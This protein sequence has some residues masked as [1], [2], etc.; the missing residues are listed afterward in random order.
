MFLDFE[1]IENAR[2]LGG[3]IR[4]DGA[5]IREGVLLRTGHLQY[6]SERD[7]ARLADMGVSL[8]VDFRDADEI[9]RH[10]DK[11]LPGAKRMHLPAL[12]DLRTLFPAVETA[13]PAQARV[14]FREMYKY[15]AI[16]P[17][18]ITAYGTLFR[19]LLAAKGKP[20][21]F[22]CT[23]GKD[24]TGVAAILIMS[25][26]GFDRE[27]CVE[28][29]LRTNEFAQGQLEAM[30]L[31]RATEEELALMAQVFP[32]FEPNVRYYFDCIDNEYGSMDNYLA[33]ALSLTCSDIARLEEYYLLC[34]S[35]F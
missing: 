22:H 32:V 14:A 3:L 5:T 35:R 11:T 21:L 30:R 27:S 31:A 20:V 23:Q 34:I 33:R 1:G 16:A 15:L 29:Y 4:A 13:T 7:L 18:A 19:E 28:E 12:P 26:L 24:R 6:A 8:V 17:E 10:P 2:D 25:A 9:R